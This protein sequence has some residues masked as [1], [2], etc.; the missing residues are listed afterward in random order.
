MLSDNS[1]MEKLLNNKHNFVFLGEAGSGK[2]EIALNF[3]MYLKACEDLPVHFFDMDQTKPL[4]RSRDAKALLEENGIVLHYEEQHLDAP[5]LV[6]GVPQALKNDEIY[7]ILDVGGNETGARMIGGFAQLLKN[8]KTLMFFVVNPYR[9]WSQDVLA[10][11]STLSAILRACRLKEI[12]VLA[13]PNVGYTTTKE[14]FLLGCE[15]VKGML[16]EYIPIQGAC[17]QEELYEAVK[18]QTA[19]PVLPIR[20]YLTYP[21]IEKM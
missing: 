17:V 9:P 7:T 11:D 21:W 3:A 10:V 18:D 13:N 1:T 5:T 15:K 12:L 16:G 6:S 14:E 8:D 2:S 4:F 20:L 19:F